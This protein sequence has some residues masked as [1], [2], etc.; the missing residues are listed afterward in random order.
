MSGEQRLA[1]H[2]RPIPYKANQRPTAL[3]LIRR[4]YDLVHTLLWA[5]GAATLVWILVN[6]PALSEARTR[7]E[8]QR[9]EGID[10][11]NHSYCEKWGMK[12]G[13]HAHTICVLDLQELRAG[14]ERRLAED[15]DGFL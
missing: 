10:A 7:A 8:A 5:L 9:A 12:A 6:L 3:V 14:H 1:V 11:E 15:A 13:T 2:A 4:V